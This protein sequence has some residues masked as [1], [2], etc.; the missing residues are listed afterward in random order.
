V[1]HGNDNDEDPTPGLLMKSL[2]LADY[3]RDEG[4][5]GKGEEE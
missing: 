3:E 5:S 2:Q 4:S 1:H